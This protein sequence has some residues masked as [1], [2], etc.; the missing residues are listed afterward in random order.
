MTDPFLDA[1]QVHRL[2]GYRVAAYQ[3][4]WLQKQGITH[5]VRADGKPVVPRAAVEGRPPVPQRA[6]PDWSAV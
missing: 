5:W 1:D 2:T 3:I 6:Q 4:R